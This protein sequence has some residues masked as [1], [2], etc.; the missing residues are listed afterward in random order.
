MSVVRTQIDATLRAIDDDWGSVET[1]ACFAVRKCSSCK[2]PQVSPHRYAGKQSP[3]SRV[4]SAHARITLDIWLR[5]TAVYEHSRRLR[6]PN[7]AFR[8]VKTSHIEITRFTTTASP[9]VS[10]GHTGWI[11]PENRE[12]APSVGPNYLQ[13]DF[14]RPPQ[15]TIPC[16]VHTSVC[17]PDFDPAAATFWDWQVLK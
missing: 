2:S 15:L 10:S 14:A 12:Y 11:S 9:Q 3:A 17:L 16:V 7:A 13:Y 4:M 8:P 5:C 1:T 6:L